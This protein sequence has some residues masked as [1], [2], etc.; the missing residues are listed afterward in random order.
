M[1]TNLFGLPAVRFTDTPE[2]P[3]TANESD[4][5]IVIP[6]AE[7]PYTPVAFQVYILSVICVCK[8]PEIP[9]T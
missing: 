3:E 4:L 7:A 9:V 8:S 1:T 2:A 6:V 5:E